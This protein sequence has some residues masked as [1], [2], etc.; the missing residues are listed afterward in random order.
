MRAR[1]AVAGLEIARRCG[2]PRDQRRRRRAGA[3]RRNARAPPAH[4]RRSR[5][6]SARLSASM[7]AFITPVATCGR[8]TNAASPTSATRPKAMRGDSRSKI[9]CRMICAVAFTSAASCGGESASASRSSAAISSGRISGGGIET[10]CE[11]PLAS[12]QSAGER[13]FRHRPEPD[14][15]AGALPSSRRPAAPA[16]GSTASARRRENR[17][18]S[19]GTSGRQAPGA[20]SSAS[21]TPRQAT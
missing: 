9:G 3:R 19:G 7:A 15:M 5:S 6:G 8:A 16:S 11:R 10:P 4:R 2:G 14:E 18:P 21:T 17:T 12:V 20:A 1:V 13:A